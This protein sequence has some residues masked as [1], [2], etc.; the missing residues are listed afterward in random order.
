MENNTFKNLKVLKT[1]QETLKENLGLKYVEKVTPFVAV[2]K[3]VMKANGINEF[4]ALKKVKEINM[5]KNEGAPLF[6]T[7]AVVEITEQ[8]HFSELVKN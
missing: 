5:Y 1:T 4:E 2:I 7:A 8:K 3:M 6:F